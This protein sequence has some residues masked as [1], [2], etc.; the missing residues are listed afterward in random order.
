M[1]F[2]KALLPW[3][4]ITFLDALARSLAAVCDPVLA[5]VGHDAERIESGIAH[6]ECIRFV[7]NPDYRLG[8]LSSLQ[9]GLRA[10]P[11]QAGGVLFTLVDHPRVRLATLRALLEDPLPLIAAPVWEG[12]RGHPVFVRQDLFGEFLSLAQD[13]TAK[14]VMH[15]HA[16][17]TRLV[18]VDDPGI[19]DDVDDTAAYERFLA[20]GEAL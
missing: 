16:A 8:Q 12:R 18:T 19:A 2:P 1:G 14:K 7:R 15:R 5:V 13:E 4:G 6:P 3:R 20:S 17:V 11:A 9:A 10:V